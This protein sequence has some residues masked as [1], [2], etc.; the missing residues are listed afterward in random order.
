M[1]DPNHEFQSP[2]PPLNE[3][4][5]NSTTEST[6]P[7]KSA[8]SRVLWIVLLIAGITVLLLAIAQISRGLMQTNTG[9]VA[10]GAGLC[11][12]G[13]VLFS[14]SFVRVEE[15]RIVYEPG[16]M[17]DDLR[18]KPRFLVAGL[19]LLFLTFAVTVALFQRV[20]MEQFI[21]E[22]M[23]RSTSSQQQS[24]QQKEMA[25]KIGK[26][27]AAVVI[28]ASVPFVVA[29]GAGLYLLGVMAFGGSISYKKALAVWVFSSLPP[30][31][32]ATLLAV[33]V[34]FLKS[35]E[36]LNPE[37]LL[38][39]NP[40]AFMDPEA[41]PALTALLG[42]F[43]LLSFYGLVLA[44]IGLRKVAR[45]SSGSAWGV[46]LGYW[47]IGTILVVSWKAITG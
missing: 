2:L 29:G 12:V 36:D 27:I 5:K 32:V 8:F 19:I 10:F 30:A 22:R 42:Q 4:A 21:R 15:M 45:L 46:V 16:Q 33:L 31:L 23:A 26:I 41:S 39:T 38:V 3:S 47:F 28:P 35:P 11:A 18:E 13:V 7:R 34:M 24:E 20:D 14:W 40:G 44:S 25:V 6:G 9:A 37:K 1:S 17:F 43:D